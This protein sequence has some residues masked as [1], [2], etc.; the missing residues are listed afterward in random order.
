MFRAKPA[1]LAGTMP[2]WVLPILAL[3]LHGGAATAQGPAVKAEGRPPLAC[4]RGRSMGRIESVIE[5]G[6]IRLASGEVVKLAGL[7]P[8]DE[9]AHAAAGAALI[10]SF[11]DNPVEVAATAAAPDRWGRL[12]AVVTA[13]TEAG[14]VD[15]A[16]ALV[17]AGLALVDAG[18]ADRLCP[19]GLLEAEARARAWGLGLWRGERYKPVAATDL[20]RLKDLAGRFA[21]VEGR[22]RSVGERRQRTYLNFGADWTTDL[23]VT[24]PKRTWRTMRDRGLT[25]ALLRGRRVRAR[26]IIEEWQGPAITIMS[27]EM[28]EILDPVT[29]DSE[30][31]RRP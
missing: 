28:L 4:E 2:A 20:E 16:R 14:P 7:R 5:R 24:I 31:P 1:A 11:K 10:E 15:L 19:P 13:A 23:T 27:P 22:I 17:A 21:L 12:A 29:L 3:A 26:G 9:P 8:P 30:S 18:E 6:E 25:A